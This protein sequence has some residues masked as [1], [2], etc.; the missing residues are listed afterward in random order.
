MKTYKSVVR[1]TIL[2]IPLAFLSYSAQAVVPQDPE[3]VIPPSGNQLL[4][5]DLGFKGRLI[6]TFVDA[7]AA[8]VG[9]PLQASQ[10]SARASAAAGVKMKHLRQTGT[11]AHVFQV[12]R[13]LSKQALETAIGNLAESAGIAH[14]EIDRLLTIAATPNDP[15]YTDQWHYYEATGGLNLPTAW[16]TTTGEGSVVAVIDTGYTS[17]SDLN[18]NLLPGYD[19]I[20]ST[21]ISN[22]GDG[23][24]SDARDTGDATSAN[25]CNDGRPARSSSWHG[26]HVAGTVAAVSNNNRGVAGVAYDAKVVPVRALGKCGGFNSDIADGIIWSAGGAVP[27][28]PTNPNPAK[29]INLSLGGGGSCSPMLQNA[30]NQAVN[31]GAVLV[32]A[33]GNESQNAANV[34]PANCANV[35]TVA[36]TGRNGGRAFYS[37]FGNVVDLAAPGGDQSTGT[38]NG[39]LSTLN[40]GQGAPAGEGYAYFQGTSMATPH[41]AGVAALMLA[42]N[43]ALTPTEIESILESTTRSFPAT[44]SGCGF[45][46]VDASAAV[47]EVSGNDPDPVGE[48][49]KGIPISNLAGAVGSEQRFTLEVPAGASDL[50]F[51]ISGGSGDADIYVRYAAEPTTATYD[52]RPWLNGNNETCSFATPSAGT[53][54]VMLRGYAAFNGVTLVADYTEPGSGQSDSIDQTGISGSRGTWSN[55]TLD[56]A[57][58][59]SSLAVQISGGSGDADLYVRFG[60]NPTTSVFDCRPYLN[61]NNETCTINNPQAGTY[62]I[63]I[64]AFR[65][66][67]GVR[68]QASAE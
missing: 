13:G 41:V 34:N 3:Q 48:L 8:S 45:G 66:F 27:G 30:I 25:E 56:V 28:V 43:D 12:N 24:D 18:A 54:H 64:R 20:S 14:V 32:V 2:L 49:E 5:N 38:S 15:S 40:N 36:A 7:Q 23:R 1:N 55:F 62:F 52:C 22:D 57:P 4:Q 46:I 35:I 67:S 58:G 10:M 44:C 16:D 21:E 37:N 26:T 61:G 9:T 50:S 63:R 65:T 60:Q 31:L 33:A 29:V 42:I 51:Q 39:V 68:L 11:G 19:M 17:H 59:Q 47:A 53:Y 6:V